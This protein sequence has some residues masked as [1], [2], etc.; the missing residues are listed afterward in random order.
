MKKHTCFA[1]QVP[2]LRDRLDS[3]SDIS[4]ITKIVIAMLHERHMEE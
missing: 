2:G 3:E 1:P 4:I